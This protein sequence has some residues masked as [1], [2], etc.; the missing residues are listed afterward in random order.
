[1]NNSQT[2]YVRDSAGT[3]PLDFDRLIFRDI[4]INSENPLMHGPMQW[5]QDKVGKHV[6]QDM[7]MGIFESGKLEK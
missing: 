6:Q 5:K 7:H 2:L 3:R 4:R 1:M